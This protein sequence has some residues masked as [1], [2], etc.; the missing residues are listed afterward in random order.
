MA[1]FNTHVFVA[2]TASGIATIT[3]L[4]AN[5]INLLDIPW[6]VFLGTVGGLLPD[7]DSDSS[8]PLKL[9]FNSLAALI[10]M[11]A[12]LAFKEQYIFQ[13]VFI[14]A[15][16]AFLIV[17]YPILSIFKYLTVHRGSIHSLL[18]AVFFTLLAVS[19]SY[20][21]FKNSIRFSWL[22]GLFIGFG[23]IVHLLLDEFYSVDLGNAQLKRSFGTAFKLFSIRYLSASITL[24]IGC[25]ALYI[26][27]PVFPFS[28]NWQLE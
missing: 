7:I 23:F 2:A 24:L 12:I 16:S 13:H 21:L 27:T 18:C 4:N 5:L 9:L 26:Y 6:F 14:I 17:R 22:S 25:I 19:L 1:N 28:L 10:A 15:S 11:L 8:R 20:Y 3:A